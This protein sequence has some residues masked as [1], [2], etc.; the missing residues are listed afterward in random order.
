MPV[1]ATELT[2]VVLHPFAEAMDGAGI[3]PRLLA[4]KLAEELEAQETKFFQFQGRVVSWRKVIAW[5]V[6]QT[7]RMDAQKLLGA[8]P[9]E[10]H[11]VSGPGGAPI[12]FGEIPEEERSLLL[13]V[14]RGM[15]KKMEAKG[16]KGK[17]RKAKT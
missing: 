7:A 1:S 12:T 2:Q 15:Q 9:A 17:R 5:G 10:K 6:R 8:Y 11:E 16:G 3:T 13:A 14:S 4:S